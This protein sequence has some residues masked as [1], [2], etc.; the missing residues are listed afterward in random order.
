M[1]NLSMA[2]LL[3]KQETKKPLSIYRGQE[4]EGTVVAILSQDI[5]LDLGTKSEGVLPKKDLSDQSLESL[6]V[7]D[8]ITAS[9]IYTENESG[10]VVLSLTRAISY[11]NPNAQK[12]AK[13]NN[14]LKSNQVLKG[15]G[16]EV[17]KGGLVVDL[18]GVRGFLPSSQVALSHAANLD[19]LVDKELDVTVLEVDPNQNRLILSQKTTVSEDTLKKLKALKSGDEVTGKVAAVLQFGIFV[20]LDDNLEGLVHVSEISWE[21]VEDPNTIFKV[22][23]T[24]KAKVISIDSTTGRANLSIKQLEKDPFTDKSKDIVPNDVLKFTV[25]KISSQ[26]LF[27]TL[28]TGLEG[29]IPSSKQEEGATYKEGD[30]LS[31]LVESVDAQKRR[32]NLSP[33]IT[34]TAGLIYK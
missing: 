14:Y 28:E 29:F 18:G 25:T 7:G 9:V 4:V 13:F 5:I 12:F 23:D 2:D 24:V 20:T 17:N 1:A 27:G 11:K 3:A 16:L 26:G 15:K 21:K 32:V 22:G 8:K 30:S 19:E 31:C 33:F 6:K 34:S 10:Q